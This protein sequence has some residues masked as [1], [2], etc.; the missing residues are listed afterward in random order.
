MLALTDV[1][2]GLGLLLAAAGLFYT[3]RQFQLSRK[4]AMA[5][6]LFQF[7]KMLS[8]Y[9]TVHM[10]LRPGGEWSSRGAGPETNEEWIEVERYMGL[11][12]RLYILTKDNLVDVVVINRLYGYRLRNINKNQIIRVEKLEKRAE[13]WRDFIAL[14]DALARVSD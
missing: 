7:D 14:R 8:E 13:G 12:E 10:K 9:Q 4:I 1:S 6:F 3:G 2:T 5:S 11:F